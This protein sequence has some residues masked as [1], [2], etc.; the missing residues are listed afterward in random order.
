[1]LNQ[2]F[3]KL[4]EWRSAPMSDRSFEDD[5]KPDATI[6]LHLLE[7]FRR[8]KT[9]FTAVSLGVFDSLESQPASSAALAGALGVNA[10]ALERL[11]DACVG[12]RLLRRE[13]AIYT[14]TPTAATYLS[15]QSA[16]RMTGY[17]KYSD[18]VLWKLWANLEDGIREGTNRW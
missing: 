16:A 5:A 12:L 13:G 15:A 7:A 4:T 11:L 3:E 1:G 17:V 14:N 6:V 9:M 2:T 8:S 18:A 10:D